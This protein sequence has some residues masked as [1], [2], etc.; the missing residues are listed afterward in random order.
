MDKHHGIQLGEPPP[1][2]S[3]FFLP[4]YALGV[5]SRPGMWG[6]VHSPGGELHPSLAPCLAGTPQKSLRL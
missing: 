6:G 1:F 2:P 3:P 4:L 5:R